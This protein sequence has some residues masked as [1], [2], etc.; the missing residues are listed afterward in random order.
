MNNKPFDYSWIV[1]II[2]AIIVVVA[3]KPVMNSIKGSREKSDKTSQWAKGKV[4]FY[5]TKTWGRDNRSCAMCHAKD[6]TLQE[7]FTSVDMKDFK[8]VELK[9]LKKT[10]GLNSMGNPDKILGK[11]NS[12]LSSGNRIEAGTMDMNN[13]RWEPLLAW[14]SHAYGN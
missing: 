8:Y 13:E 4:I 2:I 5:D 6:Y 10:Y 9:G 11:I 12:C 3:F 7:G 1:F 14:L